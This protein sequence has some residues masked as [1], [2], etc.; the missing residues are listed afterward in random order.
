L[1]RLAKA[2]RRPSHL[3]G[4]EHEAHKWRQ[5][6][7]GKHPSHTQSGEY[8]G[9]HEQR[10][11]ERGDQR[12]E[13]PRLLLEVGDEE[14]HRH[15]EQGAEEE[16]RSRGPQEH[17]APPLDQPC[18]GARVGGALHEDRP[19]RGALT[20]FGKPAFDLRGGLALALDEAS[21]QGAGQGEQ[22]AY[23]HSEDRDLQDHDRLQQRDDALTSVARLHLGQEPGQ[24]ALDAQVG[25]EAE[26]R[27][28]AGQEEDEPH[29]LPGQHLVVDDRGE[30]PDQ[31]PR[32]QQQ[33]VPGRGG[34][35]LMR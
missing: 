30:D 29:L 16:Q 10:L 32:R 22:Q 9:G 13:V 33:G 2:A 21:L 7:A 18:D 26:G 25:V 12:D 23:E 24:R 5:H 15:V 14:L 8:E 34:Q 1:G 35:E 27:G 3:D 28:E 11:H 4:R 20:R 6:E 17:A 31:E 19:F